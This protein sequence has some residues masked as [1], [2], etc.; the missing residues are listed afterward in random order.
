MI[1]DV[2]KTALVAVLCCLSSALPAQMQLKGVDHTHGAPEIRQGL[3]SGSLCG[4]PLACNYE[5]GADGFGSVCNYPDGCTDAK[6][7]NYSPCS[8]CTGNCLYQ[9]DCLRLT[10]QSGNRVLGFNGNYAPSSWVLYDLEGGTGDAQPNRLTIVGADEMGMLTSF[11]TT[12]PH[13]GTFSFVWIYN[14]GY[15]LTD[16]VF[17]RNGVW[18]YLTDYT[19]T[20]GIEGMVTFQA[21]AGDEIG[22]GIQGTTGNTGVLTVQTFLHPGTSSCAAG[23]TYEEASNYDPNAAVDN[24]TCTDFD[25]D[26]Q[27]ECPTDLDGNGEIGSGDLLALL[28]A[29]GSAC[30]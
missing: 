24:G 15:P 26:Q 18:E 4:D 6:A 9:D 30:P 3:P 1:T 12:T 27:N 25:E 17:M 7:I 10:T 8:M 22:F 29:F 19:A 28:G 2:L 11:T 5:P 20:N 13:T 21:S 23:C 14:A 16:V